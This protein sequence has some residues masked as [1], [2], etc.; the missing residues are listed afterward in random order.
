MSHSLSLL[1]AL[2]LPHT[3]KHLRIFAN[4]RQ[5]L[6]LDTFSDNAI[7]LYSLMLTIN[8]F[9]QKSLGF[10]NFGLNILYISAINFL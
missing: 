3:V 6:I 1:S 8:N 10:L 2:S 4:K 9:F 5:F 7:Y